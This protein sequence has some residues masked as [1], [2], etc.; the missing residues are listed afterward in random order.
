[1]IVPAAEMVAV[2]EPISVV[3][4]K[5][6]PLYFPPTQLGMASTLMANETDLFSLFFLLVTLRTTAF[7]LWAREGVPSIV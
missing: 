6:T 1:M 2:A 4:S 3:P 7:A 5:Q